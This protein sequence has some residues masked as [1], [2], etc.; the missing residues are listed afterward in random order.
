MWEENFGTRAG[1]H[2]REG[3]RLIWGPLNKGLTVRQIDPRPDELLLYIGFLKS[4]APPEN[5]ITDFH[6]P[7]R[8]PSA[9]FR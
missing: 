3:V 2:L 5:S 7:E 8:S 4:T 9:S 6:L 1:V